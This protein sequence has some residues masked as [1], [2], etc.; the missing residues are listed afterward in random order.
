MRIKSLTVLALLLAITSMGFATGAKEEPAKATPAT[1]ISKEPINLTWWGFY[2]MK[3]VR[4]SAAIFNEID[5]AYNA[6]FGTK[7]TIKYEYVPWDDYAGAKLMTAF[8]ANQG[9]D[10][11]FLSPPW[12]PKYVNAGVVLPVT[13]Y[14][15]SQMLKDFS[16]NLVNNTTMGNDIW[17]IPM[18]MDLL[19]LY[20][21]KALFEANKV[22]VPETF[23]ELVAAAK[24]LKA[25]DRAG[26]TVRIAS[27]DPGWCTFN[28]YP[29]VW[30]AGGDIFDGKTKKSLMNSDGVL[31]A[32]QLYKDLAVAGALNLSPSRSE[33]DLGILCDGE[34]AMQVSGSWS[35]STVEK[36][37]AEGKKTDIGVVPF[38]TPSAGGKSAS[39]AGGWGVTINAKTKE[40]D[41]VAAIMFWAFA[42]ETKFCVELDT[43]VSFAY[44]PRA[45]VVKAAGDA[46]QKGLRSIFTTKIYGTEHGELRLP[47]EGLQRIADAVQGVIYGGDPATEQAKAHKELQK[48]LDN[49]KGN[50]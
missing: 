34:T 44:S 38:P 24:A 31:K 15:T 21:N 20:Y 41:R 45:S 49:Y 11:F 14:Y 48:F 47:F 12:L 17:T 1:A 13:K 32:L 36:Y 28:W 18:N 16:L 35:I 23:A 5:D 27:T 42:E 39:C 10:I 40:P 2:K 3:D 8:A 7:Y 22:K 30:G 29:F 9:P 46:Y 19:A 26:L 6:K 25:D 50:I 43:G 37:L 33:D 4:C